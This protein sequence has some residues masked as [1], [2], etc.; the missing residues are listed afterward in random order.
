MFVRSVVFQRSCSVRGIPS[1]NRHPTVNFGVS[2]LTPR[3]RILGAFYVYG[4]ALPRRNTGSAIKGT[5]QSQV[6]KQLSC[7]I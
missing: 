1:S 3:R 7:W 5:S 2:I 4:F 6:F